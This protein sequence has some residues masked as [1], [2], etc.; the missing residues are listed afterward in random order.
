MG[1]KGKS[2]WALIR[3]GSVL[4]R[5]AYQVQAQTLVYTEDNWGPI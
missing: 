3:T 2:T 5:L 1:S 4:S